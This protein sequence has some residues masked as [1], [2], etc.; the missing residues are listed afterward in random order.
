MNTAGNTPSTIFFD[1]ECNLC[2]GSVQFILQ[3]DR[4]TTFQFASLQGQSGQEFLAKHNFPPD[5]FD[6]FILVEDDR[7][8]TRSTAALRV[9]K[10]LIFPWAWLYA[11]IVVPRF[12]CDG[13]YEFISRNRYKWFG[14]KDACWIPEPRWTKRFLP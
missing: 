7:L 2:S 11:F 12:I 6:S 3:R 9:A 1:G 13:V 4:K 10:Q 5:H 14:K 8:Y